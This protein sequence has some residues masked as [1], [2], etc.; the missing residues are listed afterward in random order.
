MMRHLI[1]ALALALAVTPALADDDAL[2]GSGSAGFEERVAACERL[3]DTAEDRVEA[4]TDLGRAYE[5]N[6]R[7]AEAVSYYDQALTL[8]PDSAYALGRRSVALGNLERWD[9]AEADLRH[10]ITVQPDRSWPRYRLGWLLNQ[11]GRYQD[12][13]ETLERAAV[14]APN[15]EPVWSELGQAHERLGNMAEA[16]RAYRQLSR[17]RPFSIWTHVTAFRTLRDAGLADEAAY[18]ARMAYTLDPNETVLETWL[19]DYVAGVEAQEMP[20]VAWMPPPEDRQIRYL[21]IRADV[22]TTDEMEAAINDLVGWFTGNARPRPTNAAIVRIWHEVAGEDFLLPHAVVEEE[23]D[24][25]DPPA[26]PAPRYRGM[27][28]LM[29]QAAGPDG[30][31][32]E[33]RF[34]VGSPADAWPL[35]AGNRAEGSGA[36]V[37]DCSRGRGF[38]FSVLGCVP[39]VDFADLGPFDWTLSV[40]AEPIHVPMGIYQTYR[41]A[42]SMQGSFTI[43]GVTNE[44]PYASVFWF[45]PDLNTWLARRLTAEGEYVYH[46]ALEIVDPTPAEAE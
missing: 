7:D 5:A 6:D 33:P 28:P 3:L 36:F 14:I 22:D 20:P 16:G 1:P 32:I 29:V 42:F 26:P 12:S 43:L 24:A 37:V 30:P 44:V 11:T 25:S 35:R 38:Q 18:H 46:L 21:A 10:L 31:I 15:Y 40:T 17:L 39:G 23:L 19:G 13:V 45:S 27:F 8:D 2:C 4:L 34:D 41:I 9:E